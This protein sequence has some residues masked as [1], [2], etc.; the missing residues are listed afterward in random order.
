[1]PRR[2]YGL[3]LCILLPRKLHKRLADECIDRQIVERLRFDGYDVVYIAE[4][5]PGISDDVVLEQANERGALLLTADKDFG[6]LVFRLHRIHAGVVL[7]RLAGISP[8]RKAE[9]VTA[10]F[11]NHAEGLLNNFNVVSPGML[12]IR[13]R[14]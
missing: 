10:A 8:E 13:T 5:D 2:R 9:I 3:T 14:E 4:L 12:R 11:R 7:L 6:E 1:M